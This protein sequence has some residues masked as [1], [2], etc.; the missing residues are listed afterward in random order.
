MS[1]GT[2]V[3]TMFAQRVAS[4][5]LQPRAQC[6]VVRTPPTQ[7]V[8]TSETHVDGDPATHIVPP[9]VSGGPSSEASPGTDPSSL[10]ASPSASSA[11]SPLASTLASDGEA[12]RGAASPASITSE[13]PHAVP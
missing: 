8:S 4:V 3:G 12:S 9:S 11:S 10:A 6:R 7:L 2:L 1:A 5:V 13:E